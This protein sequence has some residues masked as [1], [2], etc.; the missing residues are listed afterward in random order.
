MDF[1]GEAEVT[2]GIVGLLYTAGLLSLH[3]EAN[4]RTMLCVLAGRTSMSMPMNKL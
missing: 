2:S 4:G 1:A 3:L